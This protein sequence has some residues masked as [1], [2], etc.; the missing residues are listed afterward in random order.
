MPKPSAHWLLAMGIGVSLS[1]MGCSLVPL[2]T[3]QNEKAPRPRGLGQYS[4]EEVPSGAYLAS[5]AVPWD[6]D[7]QCRNT[8]MG[9][10]LPVDHCPRDD[11]H[12]V[13]MALSGGGSRAAVFSAAVMFEIQRYGLLQQ[14]DVIS[15]V[16]GGSFTAAFY[17]LSCDSGKACPKT[18]EGPPRFLWEPTTVFPLLELNYIRRW[19]LNWFWPPKILAYWLTHYDRTDIMAETLT[20][21]LY[22]N[23]LA[24]HEGFRLQDLNPQRPSL[25]IN[26]TNYTAPKEFA[27]RSENAEERVN[28]FT[29]TQEK[30][31]GLGSELG[32]FPIGYA[33]MASATFPGAFQYVTLRDF[34]LEEREEYIHLFD[35]GTYD[36]LGLNSLWTVLE[37]MVKEEKEGGSGSRGD[38]VPKLVFLVDAFTPLRGKPRED[39]D[40]RVAWDYV[41][42]SNFLDAYDTLMASLRD[43]KVNRTRTWLDIYN[44]RLVHVEFAKLKSTAPQVYQVVK[45]IKTNM[46]IDEGEAACLKQAARI[47][48]RQEMDQLKTDPRFS[49]LVADPPAAEFPIPP[50]RVPR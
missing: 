23:S 22:D 21:N 2:F 36:N 42:D 5:Y 18:V 25:L 37:N 6:L 47:L 40:P 30:F 17:A 16:S 26:A 48:V 24:G 31:R 9:P 7:L 46:K 27:A 45:G 33:V 44:G 32:Q 3:N 19:L 12:F 35:G 50:C 14:V 8:Y 10:P 20:S 34:S 28:N 41:V 15:S 13:G 43:D 1:L 39:P 49:A 29:F 38:D 4:V 11:A